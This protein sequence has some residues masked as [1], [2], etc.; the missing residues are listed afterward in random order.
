LLVSAKVSARILR[1]QLHNT[2]LFLYVFLVVWIVVLAWGMLERRRLKLEIGR[3]EVYWMGWMSLSVVSTAVLYGLGTNGIVARRFPK[4]V[5]VSDALAVGFILALPI[6]AWNRMQQ[7]RELSHRD[8][9]LSLHP[10]SGYTTLRLNEIDA[11]TPDHAHQEELATPQEG[12]TLST[13]QM[14]SPDTTAIANIDRLLESTMLTVSPKPEPIA[15]PVQTSLAAVPSPAVV[16]VEPIASTAPL[17]STKEDFRDRLKTLNE[18]W[19]RIESAGQ[20][21]DLWFEAQRREA[22]SRLEK[23][24]GA[25]GTDVATLPSKDFLSEKLAAVDADW[26][27][28]HGAAREITRWFGDSPVEKS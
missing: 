23:H 5:P 18:A 22:L 11:S 3:R 28:I 27:A 24:P 20:E 16:A 21:I 2:W 1:E 10:R 9:N 13:F 26:A 4:T 14:P 25:R 15:A 12:I 6:F 19:Q 17:V 8:E 7:R